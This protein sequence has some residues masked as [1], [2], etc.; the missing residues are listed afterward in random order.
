[1]QQYR[2]YIAQRI[3]LLQS[4]PAV[5]SERWP[6]RRSLRSRI[7]SLRAAANRARLQIGALQAETANE[8][9][10]DR[11]PCRGIRGPSGLGLIAAACEGVELAEPRGSAARCVP[12]GSAGRCT[13]TDAAG[14]EGVELAERVQLRRGQ[15][16]RIGISAEESQSAL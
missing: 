15:P 16:S 5:H 12:R 10:S 11:R 9:C 2:L 8:V 3:L 4:P 14:A 13:L 6:A 1:M 7:A